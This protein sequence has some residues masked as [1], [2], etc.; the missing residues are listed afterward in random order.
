MICF[1]YRVT[2]SSGEIVF[3]RGKR[4]IRW[5][6]QLWGRNGGRTRWQAVSVQKRY[7]S[8]YFIKFWGPDPD[9]W[10]HLPVV[11]GKLWVPNDS[12]ARQF[13][14]LWELQNQ[15]NQT[16]FVRGDR[17]LRDGKKLYRPHSSERVPF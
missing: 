3:T 2:L 4:G 6:E 14:F 15:D 13:A 7:R 5:I 9:H 1:R 16:A 10:K 11:L 8:V 12:L 17:Y